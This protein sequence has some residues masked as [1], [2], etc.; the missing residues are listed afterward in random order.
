MNLV[1]RSLRVSL[2]LVSA[3]TT[4]TARAAG[5]AQTPAAAFSA[6]VPSGGRHEIML[7]IAKWGRYSVRASGEQ[8]VAM[9]I[10]DR[11]NGIMERDGD[12]GRRNPRIDLFLDIGEYKLTVQGTKNAT[13]TTKVTAEPFAPPEGFKP[14]YLVPY[15]ENRMS[16]DDL[17]QTA[18]W[19]EAFADTSVYIE[20]VGRNL[21][22]LVLWRDGEWLVTTVNHTFISRPKD[23]TPLSGISFSARVPKG[24]YMVGAY[25]GKGRSWAVKSDEHPLCI[26]A[27]IETFPGTGFSAMTIPPRGYAQFLLHPV[28]ERFVLE[29]P[30]KKRLIAEVNRL[31]PDYQPAGWMATDSIHGK[32]SSPRITM[33]PQAM[34]WGSGYRVV[35]ISGTP[36]QSF[37]VQTMGVSE[38]QLSGIEGK[39]W[40]V[41]TLHTGNPGDQIGASG[42]VVETGKGAILAMQADTLSSGREVA[43][44]FNLLGDVSA[45]VWVDESGKYAMAPGGTEYSWRL[46]RYHFTPPPN[47][48]APEWAAGTKTIELTQGLHLLEMSPKNKGIATLVLKKASLLGGMISAGKAA[49][50]ASGENRA[51]NTPRPAMRFSGL[52]PRG[53]ENYQV[54]ANAQAPEW[55][56][57]YRRS[58]P[59][60][61]DDP[62]GFW[63][64]PG[65]KLD[66]PIK[67]AGRR[68]GWS[69]W[70]M[71]GEPSF[72][73]PGMGPGS[74]KPR[75]WTPGRIRFP[76]WAARARPG[77]WC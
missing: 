63:L 73:S 36:G 48:K 77:L 52:A 40:W 67:I 19:F 23:E 34:P 7:P 18:F 54:V 66:I 2:I 61:S 10:S 59:I 1:H 51:W 50:G 44:R 65:E 43:R 53:V 47:Y 24:M 8:P 20:A 6:S 37:T 56:S 41:S 12:A 15:R 75:N 38:F 58:L 62:L 69:A 39:S 46:G 5:I 31:G 16:L 17:Q 21:A 68:V 35:R 71:F 42:L 29:G 33:Q 64:R 22:D 72:H 27:G 11:R 55:T 74:I 9:S 14:S 30:D 76:S 57:I 3:F 4:F 26:Q 25:G 60:D 13:G 28:T 45:F 49:L 70:S 32:L